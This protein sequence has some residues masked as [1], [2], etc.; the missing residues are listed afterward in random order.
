[1]ACIT[2]F[3][4]GG[5]GSA[6]GTGA[7]RDVEYVGPGAVVGPAGFVGLPPG[8][9]ACTL[10][11]CPDGTPQAGPLAVLPGGTSELTLRIHDDVAGQLVWGALC[12]SAVADGMCSTTDH[13]VGPVC[14]PFRA[15]FLPPPA[16]VLVYAV[17]IPADPSCDSATKGTA[18]IHHATYAAP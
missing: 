10:L 3:L 12:L 6:A 5:M 16:E 9:S 14:G 18:R 11:S 2:I 8:P 13:I 15:T 4:V 17:S 7:T 1:M